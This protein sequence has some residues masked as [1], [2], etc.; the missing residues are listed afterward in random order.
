MELSELKCLDARPG[1]FVRTRFSER[2]S[3]GRPDIE[4]FLEKQKTAKQPD[5]QGVDWAECL[6]ACNLEE[7]F[8][9]LLSL[10]DE[11][12]RIPIRSDL[13]QLVTSLKQR[14]HVFFT[15]RH[16]HVIRVRSSAFLAF[17]DECFGEGDDDDTQLA[18]PDHRVAADM[19]LTHWERNVRQWREA[20]SYLCWA[21]AERIEHIR[22]SALDDYRR[23]VAVSADGTT[24]VHADWV[25]VFDEDSHTKSLFPER[26]GPS[27]R[28]FPDNAFH[29]YKIMRRS[30]MHR[31]PPQWTGRVPL[32]DVE[33]AQS[34][35]DSLSTAKRYH[36]PD[37][38]LCEIMQNGNTERRQR[39]FVT[40]RRHVPSEV[41]RDWSY[42]A[43]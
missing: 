9:P 30:D 24:I 27:L 28:I 21:L 32:G 15:E 2:P 20:R 39:I 31:M 4:E 34:A 42:S 35:S 37:Q 12:D 22:Q 5:R 23:A 43:F 40:H 7:V 33:A 13:F 17:Y 36:Y 25:A 29:E 26:P 18:Y 10:S 41:I 3:F 16:G 11:Y 6:R 14:P 1:A 19:L 38:L 8:R